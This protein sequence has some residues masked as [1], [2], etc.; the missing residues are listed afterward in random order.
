MRLVVIAPGAYPRRGRSGHLFGGRQL[1]AE[2]LGAVDDARGEEDDELAA[3]VA[4]AAALE[5]QAEDRD[6][7]EERDL[8]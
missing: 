8:S 6:V 3:G 4:G 2:G 7:A 5:E 1:R